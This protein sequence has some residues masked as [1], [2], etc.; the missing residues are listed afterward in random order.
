MQETRKL[1]PLVKAASDASDLAD[2]AWL[3]LA[4]AAGEGAAVG[5]A[6]AKKLLEASQ[7]EAS[8]DP[9]RGAV[10][11]L[12]QV[13]GGVFRVCALREKRLECCVGSRFSSQLLLI[14]T[15]LGAIRIAWKYVPGADGRRFT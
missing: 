3:L 7:A 13:G 4:R 2:C 11:L 5:G 1:D 10:L 15:G 12:Q 9:R 14:W 6:E 8:K